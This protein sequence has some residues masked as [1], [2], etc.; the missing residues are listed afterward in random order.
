L[1]TP[2]GDPAI[3]LAACYCGPLEQGENRLKPLRTFSSPLADLIRPQPF[4]EMQTLLDEAWPPGRHYYDKS[5]IVR[6]LSEDAIE[7]FLAYA[8]DMPTPLSAIA[9]Q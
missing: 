8:Q 2:D 9:F 4:L 1:T 7:M 3:G 6:R 5:S